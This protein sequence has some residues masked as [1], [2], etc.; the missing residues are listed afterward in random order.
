MA[1]K[2]SIFRLDHIVVDEKACGKDYAYSYFGD[3]SSDAEFFVAA[4]V[5]AMLYAAGSLAFYCFCGQAYQ[6]NK[7]IPLVVLVVQQTLKKLNIHIQFSKTRIS[8]SQ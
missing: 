7:T 1:K 3:Y 4:G 2:F 5:L 8:L 6:T